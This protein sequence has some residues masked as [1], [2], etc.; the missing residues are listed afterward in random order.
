MVLGFVN[1]ESNPVLLFIVR[2][3]TLCYRKLKEPLENDLQ[4]YPKVFDQ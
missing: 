4:L 2:N 3:L 1:F